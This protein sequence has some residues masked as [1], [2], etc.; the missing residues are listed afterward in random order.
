MYAKV[1]KA[2]I[3]CGDSTSLAISGFSS[4]ICWTIEPIGS[5]TSGI[6]RSSIS[7]TPGLWLFLAGPPGDLGR[8]EE[9]QNREQLPE[10]RF[11]QRF[12]HLGTADGGADR[13][14]SAHG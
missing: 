7:A 10:R 13:G 1:R 3:R 12:G 4:W 8:R 5:S 6:H 2:R 14:D 11:R 9:Q